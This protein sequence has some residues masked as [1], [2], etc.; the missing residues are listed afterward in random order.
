MAA[1]KLHQVR[2]VFEA[3]ADLSPEEQ[4]CW[5]EAHEVHPSVRQEVLA[6]VTNDESE[7]QQSAISTGPTGELDSVADDAARMDE[8]AVGVVSSDWPSVPDYKI[9]GRIGSGGM[10]VVYRARSVRLKRTV[11]LKLLP[12]SYAQ[13]ADRLER[14]QREANLLCRLNHPAICTVH[15]IGEYDGRPYIV[16]EL[17]EGRTL[18]E[19]VKEHTSAERVIHIFREAAL[20]LAAAHEEDIV[21]RDVK[22][23]NLMVRLDGYVKVLD[24]GLAR[25]LAVAEDAVGA[26]KTEVGAVLGTRR[27]MSPE[28]TR[29]S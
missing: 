9:C 24:F 27:Y 11:A 20:A 7:R 23:E 12:H 29:T 5:M 17:I 13:N 26:S 14:F 28:Q 18:R 8:P 6:L 25:E 10:G 4:H 19:L 2:A 3:V 15:D 16:M 1:G 22:P 21:H